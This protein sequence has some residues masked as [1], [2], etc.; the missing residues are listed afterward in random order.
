MF[1][2]EADIQGANSTDDSTCLFGGCTVTPPQLTA[3]FNQ[4]VPY[5]GT[6]RG[7]L[8]YSIGSTLFYGTAGFAYGQT[9]T[10]IA[11]TSSGNFEQLF[12]F[13]HNKSGYAVGGGI[14]S[15][16]GLFGPAWTIKS[17]YLFV[18][19]GQTSDTFYD[20]TA[21]LNETFTSQTREHI[22]RVGLNYHFNTPAVT[23]Y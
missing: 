11:E 7:R 10:T 18:N 9:K 1:G 14:E 4:K 16:F 15:P 8:G 13:K 19:L 22:F 12:S 21:S 17:E 3:A 2:V 23:K 5:F 20:A 6:V